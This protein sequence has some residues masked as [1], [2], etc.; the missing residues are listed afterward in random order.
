MPPTARQHPRNHLIIT[1]EK[2]SSAPHV[3]TARPIDSRF[4]RKILLEDFYSLSKFRCD[5]TSGTPRQSHRRF[6]RFFEDKIQTGTARASR[7]RPSDSARR[8]LSASNFSRKLTA[9][10]LVNRR[11]R[12]RTFYRPYLPNRFSYSAQLRRR[13]PYESPAPAARISACALVYFA[14]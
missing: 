1:E 12:L 7:I 11:S 2:L 3:Q 5:P 13:R 6:S 9:K 10:R 8:V 14:P 4:C